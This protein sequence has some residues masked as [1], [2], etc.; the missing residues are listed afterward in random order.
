MSYSP[1][2][3][4]LV[5]RD[6]RGPEESRRKPFG[7]VLASNLRDGITNSLLCS[8]K[9]TNEK[10]L[11][12]M[13]LGSE[14]NDLIEGLLRKKDDLNLDCEQHSPVNCAYSAV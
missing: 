1:F 4:H 12:R 6:L 5:K 8:L 2:S 11:K 14:R 7:A 10:L 13:D 9:L 3:S